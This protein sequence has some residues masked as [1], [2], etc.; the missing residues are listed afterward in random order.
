M[1]DEKKMRACVSDDK[2]EQFFTWY[3]DNIAE[4][5]RR[6]SGV[7]ATGTAIYTRDDFNEFLATFEVAPLGSG[8]R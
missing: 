4:A 6:D 1:S 2:Y 7:Y 8:R 5:W 3:D